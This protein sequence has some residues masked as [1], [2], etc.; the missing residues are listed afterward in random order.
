MC[1]RE[2]VCKY[3]RKFLIICCCIKI[4]SAYTSIV[5]R[6]LPCGSR[7]SPPSSYLFYSWNFQS[8][9]LESINCLKPITARRGNDNSRVHSHHIEETWMTSESRKRLKESTLALLHTTAQIRIRGRFF[10]YQLW[11]FTTNSVGALNRITTGARSQ[12][13][14]YTCTHMRSR[15]HFSN[16]AGIKY[17]QRSTGCSTFSIEFTCIGYFPRD[18]CGYN[19]SESRLR[20]DS[21]PQRVSLILL[22]LSL[23][24]L[25][26]L[27][28]LLCTCKHSTTA[29]L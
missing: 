18:A 14:S 24:L 9:M 25:L 28:P 8:A 27:L 12:P 10:N 20:A 2:S 21:T 22:T 7:V 26:T 15:T 4:T 1:V 11:R 23:P 6:L 17:R 29:D 13:S 16:V 5:I 3:V 19:H